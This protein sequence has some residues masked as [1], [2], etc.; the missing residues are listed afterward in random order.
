[1][2]IICIYY[3]LYTYIGAVG[4]AGYVMYSVYWL[5]YAFHLYMKVA[6]PEYSKL[7]DNWNRTKKLYYFEVGFVTIIG[8]VPYIIL[9]GLS[10]FNISQFPPL[11]CTFNAAGNFY[12]IILPTL[13]LN[14]STVIILLLVLYHVYIV[15]DFSNSNNFVIAI[16]VLPGAVRKRHGQAK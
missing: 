13:I 10:E 1:M 7:L 14:C 9:A 16:F 3:T 2:Y 8:T 4:V 5:L 12:G 11:A 15:S 6:K